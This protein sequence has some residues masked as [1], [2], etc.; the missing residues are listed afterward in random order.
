MISIRSLDHV[1]VNCSDPER[2]LVWYRDVLGLLP[3]REEEW[4]AGT[5]PF[6]SLRIDA[7]SVIDLFRAERTG[8]N[9]DHFSLC[10][11]PSV[12]L[13]AVAASG[14]VE[15]VSGPNRIWGARG[16]GT[17]LYVRDPDGNVVELKHHPE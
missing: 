3:E 11:D 12:D 5:A 4:R 2:S 8:V 16:W 9:V 13:A 14:I 10:V 15:V 7:T 6:V 17:G 1:V